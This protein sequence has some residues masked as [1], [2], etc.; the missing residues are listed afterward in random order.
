MKALSTQQCSYYSS[1]R[2]TTLQ[3]QLR[4]Q[5]LFL[6][7]DDGED[8]GEPTTIS[9]LVTAVLLLPQAEVLAQEEVLD[10]G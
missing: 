9:H 1:W 5:S 6:S 3:L 4:I 10:R 7:L 2:V 8:P